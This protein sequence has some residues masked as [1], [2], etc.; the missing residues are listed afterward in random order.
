MGVTREGIFRKESKPFFSLDKYGIGLYYKIQKSP[1]STRYL[2]KLTKV[3][4]KPNF[5]HLISRNSTK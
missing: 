2:M 3:A 5:I 4:F 1:L